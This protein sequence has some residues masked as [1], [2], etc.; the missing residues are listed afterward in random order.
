MERGN[1]GLELC[2]FGQE[3]FETLLVSSAHPLIEGHIG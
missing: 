3:A 1:L 2:L